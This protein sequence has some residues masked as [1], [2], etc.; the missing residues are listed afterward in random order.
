M[1][2]YETMCGM[3]SAGVGVG[4]L[5]ESCA[6]RYIRAGLPVKVVKLSDP[7]SLRERLLIYRELEALPL[8]ARAF[9]ETLVGMQHP[10]SHPG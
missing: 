1:S 3:I 8:C 4:V 7:W 6:K 5:P 10:E 9:V 2:S